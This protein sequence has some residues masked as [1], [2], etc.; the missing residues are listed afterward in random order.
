MEATVHAA[1]LGDDVRRA[2]EQLSADE[3]EAIVLS[4]FG[5][6]SYRET[7]EMLGAPEGTVKT[8]IPAGP[9]WNCAGRW[10]TRGDAV[11]VAPYRHH[12]A[13]RPGRLRP[14]RGRRPGRAA[15]DRAPSGR[16][17]AVPPAAGG[18]RGHAGL[19]RD[20]RGPARQRVG[21]H[22]RAHRRRRAPCRSPRRV[23][24]R[25]GH[26]A[27]GAKRRRAGSGVAG[28]RRSWPWRPP[29][30]RRWRPAPNCSAPGVTAGRHRAPR[31]H[32]PTLGVLTGADGAEVARVRAGQDGPAVELTG[33]ALLP[34]GHT[35]LW[36]LD[37]D[38]PASA[39]PAGRRHRHDR[40]RLLPAGTRR[41]AISDEPA[42]GSPAPQAW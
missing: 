36:S 8:R 27:R 5:G 11:T 35:W 38:R 24:V 42:G 20:R 6:H 15:G 16:V 1:A 4:Y 13:G 21:R 33:V 29:S 41:V 17:Q 40:G 28:W 14:R 9:R 30:W 18:R 37:G 3:Q 7:A 32:A 19:A 22:R 12:P 34:Q 25:A 23:R 31:W 26:T 2:V 39:Q 10:R